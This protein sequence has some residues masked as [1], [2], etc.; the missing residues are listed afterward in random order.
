MIEET[1][2]KKPIKIVVT[3]PCLNEEFFARKFCERHQWA[4][5]IV[6]SDGGSTDKTLDIVREFPNVRVAPF[7]EKKRFKGDPDGF[8]N[9][10]GRHFNQAVQAARLFDPDWIVFEA[11]DQYPNCDDS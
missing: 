9:P 4:D 10:E 11:M 1:E 6:V 8:M 3:V 7:R 2:K 5:I